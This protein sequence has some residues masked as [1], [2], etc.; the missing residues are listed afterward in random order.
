[1]K[2][3]VWTSRVSLG[4][5]SAALGSRRNLKFV[6]LMADKWTLMASKSIKLLLLWTRHYATKNYIAWQQ[7]QLSSSFIWLASS[8]FPSVCF[9]RR[10]DTLQANKVCYMYRF[11]LVA[12]KRARREMYVERWARI[13]W[14]RE[15]FGGPMWAPTESTNWISMLSWSL[16]SRI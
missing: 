6:A 3:N 8:S 12:F 10:L 15:Q 2:G 14:W 5:I 4:K 1:M 11:S 13:P 9:G 16:W 7:Q